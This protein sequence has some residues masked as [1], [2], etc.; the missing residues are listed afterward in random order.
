MLTYCKILEAPFLVLETP[1]SYEFTSGAIKDAGELLTSANLGNIRIVWENRSPL[2]NEAK[3]LMQDLSIVQGTDMS[4][5]EPLFSSD[6]LYTRLFGKG[7]H[8]IYQ[9]SDEELEQIA[10]KISTVRPKVAA[11][12]YHGIRMNTDALRF[13][14]YQKTGKFPQVTSFTGVESAKTVLAEDTKFPSSKQSLIAEQGWKIFDATS[15]KRVHLS[16]WLTQ[17]PN[18]TYNNINEVAK[19]LKDIK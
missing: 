9:F 10:N 8:N 6:V 5:Q 16:E 4:V 18:K 1:P 3:S 19:A 2:T 13:S 17:I 11:L 7:R 15:D 14:H 12:S